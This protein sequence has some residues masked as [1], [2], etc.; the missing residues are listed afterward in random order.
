MKAIFLSNLSTAYGRY[1]E[2]FVLSRLGHSRFNLQ[3]SKRK[4]HKRRL[5]YLGNFLAQ[6]YNHRGETDDAS[7]ELVQ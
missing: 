7:G 6:L 1:L 5:G 3:F 4:A 2:H